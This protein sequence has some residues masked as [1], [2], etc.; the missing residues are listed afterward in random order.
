MRISFLL[1]LLSLATAC[2]KDD[3]KVSSADSTT[4]GSTG[5]TSGGSSTGSSSSGQTD[6]LVSEAWHLDNTGT[7]KAFSSTAGLAGKDINVKEVHA[8][9]DILGR[10]VRIAVSDSGLDTLHADLSANMLAGEHRNYTSP[11]STDWP[12]ASPAPVG[13]EAHGTMVT[14]LIAAV[15]WNGIGSRGV[16]PAAQVAGFRYIYDVGS[17]TAVSRKAKEIDQL[18]GEFDIFNFS[19][20]KVGYVFVE[21][22]EDVADAVELG[23]TTLRSGKGTNYVQSA[24]NSNYEQYYYCDPSTDPWGAAC[25]FQVTGNSNAHETLATPFKIVVG[26]TNARDERSS[27][28]TPGSNLWVSAP[29]GE[30]G[31]SSPAMI[32][33]DITGCGRGNS[34]RNSAYAQYFDFGFNT[35]NLMC[36]YTNTMNGTSSAA[37]VTSGVIAL[38][39]EAR[40]QLTWRDV[41]HILAVTADV[42]DYDAF[43]NVLEHPLAFDIFGYQYDEKWTLNNASPRRYFS[44]YYGFG[45]VNAGNAVAMA[46][47]YNLSTLGTF[48]QTKNSFGT[49]YYQSDFTVPLPIIDE[50]AAPTED[51]IWVGH[52]Y[53]IES[54]QISVSSNHPFPGDLAIHLVSP[55]GTESRLMTLNNKIYGDTLT[56]DD[57]VF[58]SNAFYG[59]ESVGYWRIKIYDGDSLLGTGNLDGW[60][61][62]VSGHKKSTELSR[63]YPPTFLTLSATPVSDSVTPVFG[64]SD[65]A[66]ASSVWWYEAAV[67]LTPDDESVKGWTNIGLSTSSQ[68]LTG[69]STMLDGQT[70]YLK[71]RARS[72]G[73]YSSVQVK[74]WAAD[75]IP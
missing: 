65:S 60:K 14:G 48:E 66:S 17:E 10:N 13:D 4:G 1:L 55:A 6:P 3:G 15:G 45:R 26:A 16:A 22:D 5:S 70:Y 25:L 37:P 36:D 63:P 12:N 8:D 30:Y 69:L 64:F 62:L 32:T 71:L 40:P 61:I 67:G 72:S 53:I 27:Y 2:V 58:L 59:E 57:R 68:Q 7:N 19:Y 44:N 51:I 24:G 31:Y 52:N 42:V 43:D 74:K 29:G 73:G 23:I 33:T 38:M 50:S 46:K 9:S 54:V 56:L 75:T 35:L 21:E 34:K 18:Y 28:S 41:K 11:T 20:G 39:L 47:T 49:W